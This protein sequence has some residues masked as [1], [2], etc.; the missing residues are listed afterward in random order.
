MRML[1]ARRLRRFSISPSISCT[2]SE[3]FSR[4]S[5]VLTFSMV[6]CINRFLQVGLLG[7]AACGS[8]DR[9]V[10][11]RLASWAAG[12]WCE[13]RDSNSH[14]FRRQNLNLVR[15]PIP[16]L[17]QCSHFYNTPSRM[18]PPSGALRAPAGHPITLLIDD[19]PFQMGT[20][21]PCGSPL[22]ELSGRLLAASGRAA[23]ARTARSTPSPARPTTSRTKETTRRSSAWTSCASFGRELDCIERGQ[24]ARLPLF[25]LLAPVIREQRLPVP[26]FRDLLSA[27]A[28]DVTKTRY[29]DFGEVMS[30]CRRSANPVG[31][32]LLHLF[33]ETDTAQPR[34][35]RR[36]LL[37][38]ATHQLSAGHRDRLRQGAYLSA[39][40]TRCDATASPR[41]RSPPATRA[42]D[43]RR[44]C[45]SRSSAH[46]GC[47]RPARRWDACSRAASASS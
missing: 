27:F 43:G 22:R 40:R 44:S 9:G 15:L 1:R 10:A 5:R 28:Q 35:F 20:Q 30:Y 14:A 23:R 36:D 46:A 3:T 24:P 6:A 2:G 32:L 19:S 11:P 37:S 25:Q 42:A 13:R 7:C 33:G 4:R 8:D 16:P 38:A 12:L 31:R 34:L 17:S 21:A 29:D 18:L 39:R 41:R 47:C 26:L 45:A